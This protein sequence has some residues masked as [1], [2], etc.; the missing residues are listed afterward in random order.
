M[1]TISDVTQI[2]HHDFSFI[3]AGFKMAYVPYTSLAQ[4]DEERFFHVL[5]PTLRVAFLFGPWRIYEGWRGTLS[6]ICHLILL[7]F[8]LFIFVTAVF[9]RSTIDVW[10][11]FSIYIV[12]LVSM[13]AGASIFSS[14]AYRRLLNRRISTRAMVS[15]LI[16]ET[17]EDKPNQH[18]MSPAHDRRWL[19]TMAV[20]S[21][22]YPFALELMQWCG[23]FAFHLSLKDYNFTGKM[24]KSIFVPFDQTAWLV[25]Y[26][27][28][29]V[30]SAFVVGF[31]TFQFIFVSRLIMRDVTSLMSLFG[32]SPFLKLRPSHISYLLGKSCMGKIISAVTG[33]LSMDV[34]DSDI[35]MYI[36]SKQATISRNTER[37]SKIPVRCLEEGT[38]ENLVELTDDFDVSLS[39]HEA[40]RIL[41]HFISEIAE[42][43]SY[44]KPFT[45]TVTF[46]SITNLVTHVCLF[47]M[48][49]NEHVHFWTLFRT[50][51]FLLIAVRVLI[52][53]SQISSVLS[54]IPAHIKYLR[55]VGKLPGEAKEWDYFLAL[56]E[57]LRLEKRSFGFP[58]TL[59]QVASLATFLNMSFLIVLSVMKAQTGGKT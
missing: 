15:F 36:G 11:Q 19:R 47:A 48:G 32:Y 43:T 42:I 55:A 29:W 40:S 38:A 33:F 7:L 18:Q 5:K 2:R 3:P 6:R 10:I 52:C 59:R 58:M 50:I 35:D 28:F 14:N 37:P 4:T 24:I 17:V 8:M 16:T 51:L 30:T 53:V 41:T 22:F 1:V 21:C 57:T 23:Y 56:V 46:F 20:K 26:F 25:L 9:F 31:L 39:E 44:F 27:T 54:K 49:H 34:L 45:V 12:P 13:M